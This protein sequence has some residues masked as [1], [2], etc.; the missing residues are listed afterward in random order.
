MISF[1][2]NL[3]NCSCFLFRSADYTKHFTEDHATV[4]EISCGKC[5]QT[6]VT[7]SLA[8]KHRLLYHEEG[9]FRCT[10]CPFIGQTRWSVMEH[11]QQDHQVVTGATAAP[12]VSSSAP[13]SSR[14][15]AVALPAKPLQKFIAV[16]LGC[17]QMECTESFTC[18][19]RLNE[20]LAGEHQIYTQRCIVEN[21]G[22]SFEERLVFLV[23]I[24]IMLFI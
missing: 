7:P 4:K 20:H 15:S 6:S 14:G 19:G 22:Q 18:R 5:G 24:M 1:G 17:L 10:A 11:H 16:K 12:T 23:L 13:S 8:H 21:C 3:P 2:L 9:E